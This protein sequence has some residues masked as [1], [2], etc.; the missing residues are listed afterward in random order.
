MNANNYIELRLPK[1]TFEMP[2]TDSIME[3]EKLRYKILRGTTH[4]HVFFQLRHIFHMLESIGSSRIEGNNTTVMD[5]IE[6]AKLQNKHSYLFNN[7]EDIQEIENV[8]SAMNYIEQNI[9]DIEINKMFLRELH[10][11]TVKN[12][13]VKREG[14]ANPGE[15]RRSNVRISGS[16]HIP[17]DYMQV[18]PLVDELIKFLNSHNS[19]KYDLLKIA[20]S[21]HRFVWI[22]PFENGNGR[23]VRL[24]TYA[25]LLKYIFQSRDR[26]INP[27]A[28]FCSDRNK[29]Y[30]YLAKADTGT[31]KGLIDWAEYVLSGLKIEIEKI[32]K[33]IDYDYLQSKILLPTLAD[34]FDK[35]YI[36]PQE[37]AILKVTINRQVMQAGD[38]KPILHEKTGSD[39]SRLIKGLIGKQMLRPLHAG[40]RKYTIAFSN[41]FLLRSIL[42]V[43][44][45]ND[46]LPRNNVLTS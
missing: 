29:Y 37:Y 15:F 12:L 30:E 40:A 10:L 22:H 25:L 43:L 16:V 8:E 26:I 19:P 18:E 21:H 36:T 1:I 23:V 34:A 31:D 28:V 33:L 2:I 46:F 38:I 14:A 44:D 9:S 35:K 6:T 3:L 39:I 11:M 45:Q 27:T 7:E 20:I 4:P 5:Y 42:T 13:S 17:P 24:F 32:D 41:N